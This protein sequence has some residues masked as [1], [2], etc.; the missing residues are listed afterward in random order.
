MRADCRLEDTFA[1]VCCRAA[2]LLGLDSDY[3]TV[4]FTSTNAFSLCITVGECCGW[5]HL[6]Q[7]DRCRDLVG[8]RLGVD[9]A[10]IEL[11]GFSFHDGMSDDEYQRSVARMWRE[12][13]L[14]FRAAMDAG[15]IILCGDDWLAE[16]PHGFQP[17]LEW[18]II[19]RAVS[20]EPLVGAT[21]NGYSDNPVADP[22]SCLS[23]NRTGQLADGYDCDVRT[24]RLAVERFR[25]VGRYEPA[26]PWVF[27]RA[28]MDL[29]VRQM[30]TVQGFCPGC[31]EGQPDRAWTDANAT[32]LTV[33]GGARTVASYLNRRT[34]SFPESTRQHISAAAG[35]YQVIAKTLEPF[36]G[37]ESQYRSVMGDLDKQR[38]HAAKVL[39]PIRDEM[40]SATDEI[41]KA[42]RRLS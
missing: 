21:M 36:T 5:W 35:H 34:G 40:A 7:K 32:A 10:K 42:L 12:T 41:E 19:T 14:T 15:S 38:E 23:V 30:A 33:L 20:G 31:F 37:Q 8:E 1:I 18:G 29:W 28:A 4:Y 13:P 3:E 22:G 9:M 6:H 11:P 25:G 16:G 27:G 26:P 39:K 24:L 2:E 17:W